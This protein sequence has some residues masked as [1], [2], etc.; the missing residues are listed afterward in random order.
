MGIDPESYFPKD[1]NNF[2]KEIG[3]DTSKYKLH[4]AFDDAKLLREVYLKMIKG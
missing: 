3:V 1:K 4:N 2:F